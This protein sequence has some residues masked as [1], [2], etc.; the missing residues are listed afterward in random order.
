[1]YLENFARA[2]AEKISEMKKMLAEHERQQRVNS[3]PHK[4]GCSRSEDIETIL[5]TRKYVISGLSDP[6]MPLIYVDNGELVTRCTECEEE[7]RERFVNGGREE[8]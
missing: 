5:D 7:R 4:P 3:H 6:R 8:V 1:M 2:A